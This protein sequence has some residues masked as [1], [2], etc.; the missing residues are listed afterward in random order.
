MQEAAL[1]DLRPALLRG[2]RR[3]TSHYSKAN[4]AFLE[5]MV[6]EALIRILERLDQFEGR[7]RFVT[8]A[9]SIAVRIAISELRRHRW[10]D[11]SL[12]DL[13]EAG[14]VSGAH[15][16][17][18]KEV[19]VELHSAQRAL[20]DAMYEVMHRELT[21]RQRTALLAELRGMPQAEIGRSLG[22]NRN[23]IYKLTYDARKKLRR[24]L[25]DAG[26][27]GDDVQAAFVA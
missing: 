1:A 22:S 21:E 10:R 17:A 2:L 11:V 19:E 9:T 7:S 15:Q 23:A 8:W 3:A 27:R 18:S 16:L 24:G 12:D 5:D 6:Q 13:I 26:Y 14:K 4:E 25:E 20:V